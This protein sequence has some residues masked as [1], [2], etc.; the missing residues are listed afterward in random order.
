MSAS[1]LAAG[2]EPLLVLSFV[3]LTS[4]PPRIVLH[5]RPAPG[6]VSFPRVLTAV[7]LATGLNAATYFELNW[8]FGSFL[9]V[10][11]LYR[12]LSSPFRRVFSLR[13]MML[14]MIAWLALTFLLSGL[15]I[16]YVANYWMDGAAGDGTLDPSITGA[17]DTASITSSDVTRYM[18]LILPFAFSVFPG[19]LVSI[20]FATPARISG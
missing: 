10:A 16:L 19:V 5:F 14:C 9:T 13:V 8:A 1:L 6:T 11:L 18:N 20:A 17:S 15:V 7:A 3:D 12:S 2:S 4:H